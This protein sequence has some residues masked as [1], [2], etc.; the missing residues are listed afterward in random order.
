LCAG[1]VIGRKGFQ[2]GLMGFRRLDGE[3]IIAN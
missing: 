2:L 1:R 3:R